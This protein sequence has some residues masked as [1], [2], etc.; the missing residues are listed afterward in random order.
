VVVYDTSTG[1]VGASRSAEALPLW[2]YTTKAGLTAPPVIL[3]GA[4][5]IGAQDW[6]LYCFTPYGQQPTAGPRR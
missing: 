4:I 6:N 1:V 5:Y 2:Q 3:N